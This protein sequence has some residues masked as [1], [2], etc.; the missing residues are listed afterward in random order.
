MQNAGRAKALLAYRMKLR[1]LFKSQ[2]HMTSAVCCSIDRGLLTRYDH[3]SH[4]KGQ[5]RN[6]CYHLPLLHGNLIHLSVTYCVA[7]RG[8]TGGP[9]ALIAPPA[10]EADLMA[11]TCR[12]RGPKGSPDANCGTNILDDVA[13]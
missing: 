11:R 8:N 3:T 1:T 10:D 12:A 7:S 2:S 5:A 13:R 9:A 4:G 6:K